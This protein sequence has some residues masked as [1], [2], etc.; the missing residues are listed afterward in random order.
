MRRHIERPRLRARLELV[1][2][3]DGF[4]PPRWT[5]RTAF[6]PASDASVPQAAGR[7]GAARALV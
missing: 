3:F 1:L 4:V 6:V 5:A 2:R 7:S